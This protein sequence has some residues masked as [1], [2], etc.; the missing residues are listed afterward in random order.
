MFFYIDESGHTG[1]NLFDENQ[2]YLYYGV[3]GSNLNLDILA[4]TTVLDLRKKVGATDRLHAAEL[5]EEKLSLIIPD[6]LN[7]TKKLDLSFDFYRVRKDDYPVICFFDQVFDQGVNP[8]MTWSGYWTPLRYVLLAKINSLFT[9]ELKKLAWEARLEAK[10]AICDQKVVYICESLLNSL[11]KIPDSRSQQIIGDTLLWAIKHTRELSFNAKTKNDRKFI[12]PNLIG[13]QAAYFGII[14]R[15]KKKKRKVLGIKI[16][17]QHEFNTSQDFL[18]ELYRKIEGTYSPIGFHIGEM[19][20][21]GVKMPSPQFC[22]SK[23]SYGLELVDLYLWIIKRAI[24]E[25]LYSI[26]LKYFVIKL[27]NKIYTDEV[28]IHSTLVRL[29]KWLAETP[30]PSEEQIMLN[31]E[32]FK[33]DEERRLKHTQDLSLP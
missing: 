30:A 4:E 5:G 15:S 10:D 16:D 17:Q 8:A 25:K 27:S 3:L 14:N 9:N 28:S 6:L 33:R 26:S 20:F 12:S 18:L 31:Q 13:L 32:L 29:E 11:H 23:K 22:S 7:I 1:N 19:D 24:E 21:R 2:P